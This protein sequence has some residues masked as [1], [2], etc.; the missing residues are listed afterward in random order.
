M[1]ELIL[2]QA[3]ILIPIVLIVLPFIF[4]VLP[5]VIITLFGFANGINGIPE[6]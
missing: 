3:A 1:N 6:I 5:G 4:V 2:M